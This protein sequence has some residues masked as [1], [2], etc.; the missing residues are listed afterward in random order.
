MFQSSCNVL[1]SPA[2][3]LAAITWDDKDIYD[4]FGMMVLPNKLRDEGWVAKFVAGD[5]NCAWRALAMGIWGSDGF[6]IQLKLAVLAWTAANAEELVSEGR[7][8]WK[9]DRYFSQRV[10]KYARFTSRGDDVSTR[11]DNT[12][13]VIA[14]V[15]WFGKP[16][17]WGGDLTMLM[18]SQALR[19]RVKL[20]API[21][22]K[23]RKV[24][25]ARESL[26]A[27]GMGEK[28]APPQGTG[29]KGSNMVED[30]R[31][32]REFLTDDAP[33]VYRV[34]GDDGSERHIEEVTV[35]LTGGI[36]KVGNWSCPA[37]PKWKRTR[38]SLRGA[39]LELL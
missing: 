20:V 27:R 28:V 15:G 18:A 13:M 16:N 33:L 22:R 14:S 6:W 24:R 38:I 3:G 31:F 35:V 17:V 34:P 5:G 36:T 32:S 10:M 23:S 7:I 2:P 29:R 1:T 9:C 26:A 4:F 39:T 19:L 37:F 25:D 30:Y 8:L 11:A 12:K 21:D